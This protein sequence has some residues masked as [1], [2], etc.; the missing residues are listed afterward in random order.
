MAPTP[1]LRWVE[2]AADASRDV[3]CLADAAFAPS[4]AGGL[5]TGFF[6]AMVFSLR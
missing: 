6:S 2:L 1:S 5:Y 4:A 3:G